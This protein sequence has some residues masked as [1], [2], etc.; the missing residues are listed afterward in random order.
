MRVTQQ[1]IAR[2]ANVSQATVSRVL[3]GDV[4]VEP[5]KRTAVLDAMKRSN[6]RPDVRAQ[7]LRR[8]RTCLIGL[9]LKRSDGGI[10]DDPFFASLIS[11]LARVLKPSK[12]HLCLDIARDSSDQSSVYDELL[13]SRR[14][15]GLVLVEPEADDRRL[16]RL[17][18]DRFPFVVIG[19]PR[20]RALHSFDN[21]NVLAARMATMHLLDNGFRRVGMLAGPTGVTV[22]D[23]RV[24]G[25]RMAMSERGFSDQVWHSDF[26]FEAACT[27]AESLLNDSN[28]EGLVCMD[29]FMATGVTRAAR[30][31]GISIPGDLAMVSF[32][33][34][35][36][37]NLI[38]GGLTSVN[39]NHETMIREAVSKL[40]GL[41]ES[42]ERSEPSR[43][44][45]PCELKVRG[46]SMRKVGGGLL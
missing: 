29:D 46:S 40:I 38:D 17:Q 18:E 30:H 41:I 21:D 16:I 26:G 34:S 45:I 25:Y 1:E 28:L 44:V 35:N 13:R 4:R 39:M 37:C 3:A 23:D 20:G 31:L 22:S 27:T 9:V 10:K 14:V 36:L 42:T 11:E 19:N 6:Y 33:D 24:L 5:E 32:N 7:A 15:D 8:K 2:I 43:M 12:Y